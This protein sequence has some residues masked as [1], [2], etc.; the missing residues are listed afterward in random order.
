MTTPMRDRTGIVDQL[1]RA[2]PAVSGTMRRDQ[3]T[4]EWVAIASHRQDRTFLPPADECP[5]CPTRGAG[6]PS[7][8]PASDYNVV[9]FENRFPSF[10]SQAMDPGATAGPL[11]CQPTR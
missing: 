8:V 3:L 1:P 5:L 2:G 9:V 6:A 11:F 4:G 10:S 7:E